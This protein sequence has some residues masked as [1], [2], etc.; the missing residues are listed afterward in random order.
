MQE[1][2]K[3]LDVIVGYSD[4]T[5]GSQVPIMAV[6]LGAQVIEKHFTLDNK[7][8]GPDHNASAD[9]QIFKEM[10][11]GIRKVE[12]ILGSKEKRPTSSE[13][14]NINI[15]RKSIVATT[16]IKRGDI[17]SDKNISIKRPGTGLAPKYYFKIMG[18]KCK[19]DIKF[20]DL[21]KKDCF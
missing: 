3:K 16:N 14:K 18:K 1:M 11:F 10:V 21:I 17:F 8:Q 20:G 7:M 19:R 15:V 9:P 12:E 6:T 4:H 5:L 13:I 2:I